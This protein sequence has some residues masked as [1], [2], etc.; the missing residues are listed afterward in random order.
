MSD[1]VIQHSHLQDMLLHSG[2]LGLAH[3][4][5]NEEPLPFGWVRSEDGKL[6]Q[7]KTVL[8]S[9]PRARI[10]PYGH[11][12]VYS[13]PRV[14]LLHLAANAIP[15]G[16]RITGKEVPQELV[17]LGNCLAVL[18]LGFLEHLLGLLDLQLAGLHVIIG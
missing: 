10:P 12:T 14:T 5:L 3:H 17:C 16:L 15:L 4:L 2:P 9:G 1:I 11:L 18:I 8:E 13:S 7:L 6:M